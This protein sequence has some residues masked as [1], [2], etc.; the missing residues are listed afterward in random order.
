M[1]FA[2]RLRR[3]RRSP[4]PG[5]LAGGTR[6]ASG[7]GPWR[8]GPGRED[9][10]AYEGQR[11]LLRNPAAG[12]TNTGSQ[13]GDAR[14]WGEGNQSRRR[15][16]TEKKEGKDT[17]FPVCLPK[18]L[19]LWTPLWTVRRP[20]NAR[21]TGAVPSLGNVVP[22]VRTTVPIRQQGTSTDFGRIFL[23]VAAPP[24]PASSGLL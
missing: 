7:S 8:H 11:L 17:L 19:R 1:S 13:T 22:K 24:R 23:P 14:Q 21:P 10:R 5:D 4:Q 3:A 20:R 9:D 6:W 12:K 2:P 18:A 15:H 16:S